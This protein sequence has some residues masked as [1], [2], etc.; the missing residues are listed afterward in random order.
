M[1]KFLLVINT[2]LFFVATMNLCYAVP[3]PVFYVWYEVIYFLIPFIVSL[4]WTLLYFFKTKLNVINIGIWALGW[5]LYVTHYVITASPILSFYEIFSLGIIF[6]LLFFSLKKTLYIKILCFV[7]LVPFLILSINSTI[8]IYHFLWA[9]RNI[10]STLLKEWIHTKID[11]I[12]D[13]QIILS[14]QWSWVVTLVIVKN[15]ENCNLQYLNE[16]AY[17]LKWWKTK[18]ADIIVQTLLEENASNK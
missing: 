1:R 10:Q 7:L 11:T 5:I 6:L 2:I 13:S 9:Y 14:I 16:C 18:E 8:N 3:V 4:S 17:F 12:K 15:I